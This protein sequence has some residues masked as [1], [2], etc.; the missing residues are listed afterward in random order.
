MSA[1]DLINWSKFHNWIG[2]DWIGILHKTVIQ[3]LSPSP[4]FSPLSSLKHSL[5]ISHFPTFVEAW[6]TLLRPRDRLCKNVFV[7][8]YAQVARG[9]CE[10]VKSIFTKELWRVLTEVAYICTTMVS[11]ACKFWLNFLS[12]SHW[13]LASIPSCWMRP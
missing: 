1:V 7:H 13:A 3:C 11:V 5:P 6:P 8:D 10:L 4:T 2:L 12:L 9:L